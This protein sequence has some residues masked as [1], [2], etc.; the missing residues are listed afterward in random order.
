MSDP[1]KVKLSARNFAALPSEADIALLNKLAAYGVAQPKRTWPHPEL[2]EAVISLWPLVQ[3]HNWTFGDLINVLRDVL[4]QSEIYPC[5]SERNLATYCAF[6]LRLRRFGQGKTTRQSRPPGYELALR[7]CLPQKA[8]AP[9]A[10]R[11]GNVEEEINE[12]A[13]IRNV[14]EFGGPKQLAFDAGLGF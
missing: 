8:D 10:R 9:A 13:P 7:L 5:Q 4:P 3:R 1:G 14:A 6:T 12:R 11:F 2:D